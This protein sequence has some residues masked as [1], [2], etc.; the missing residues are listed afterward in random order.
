[1]S[2]VAVAVAGIAAVSTVAV[3]VMQNNTQK[4]LNQATIE[5]MQNDDRLKLISATSQVALDAEIANAKTDTD[6]IKIYENALAQLGGA[7]IDS[8]GEIF[9]VGAKT[10]TQEN[11]LT[12]SIIV[13]SGFMLIGGAIYILRKK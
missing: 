6:R 4:T 11:Y 5:S 8:T 2:A 3:G 10:K 13:A 9:A 1:M 12:K 7:A